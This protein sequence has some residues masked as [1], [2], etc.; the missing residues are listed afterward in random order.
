MSQN[1]KNDIVKYIEINKDKIDV[2][3]GGVD[4]EKFSKIKKDEAK[5]FIQKQYGIQNYIYSPT[6]LYPRKNNDLLVKVFAK[7]KKDKKVLQKLIITGIDPQNK[8]K[9][10]RSIISK[11]GMESEIFYLGRVPGEHLS[12]L[13][14]GADITVYLSSYEGFGLPILE[15][16]ASSCPVLSSNRSSLPEVLG[17]AGV[18][19][20]PFNIEEVANRMYELLTNESLRKECIS[21]GS[22][23][24]KQFSWG[25]VARRLIKIYSNL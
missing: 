17:D 8:K 11:Y 2:I 3:Y 14:S 21:K 5:R 24:A 6:S 13:Y 7:L 12:Y 20:N 15:A 19:V 25:N 22:V 16:M 9:W 23:R 1:T 10:L 4:F 18:L